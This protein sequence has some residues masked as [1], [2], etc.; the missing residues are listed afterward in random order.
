MF[1]NHSGEFAALLTAVFWTITAMAF[2]VATKRVG[3]Y[4]VNI[5][6]LFFAII[7][8]A[9]LTFFRRGMVLPMDASVHAWV[10]LSI[11]GLVGFI[12]GDLFLFASY[13]IITSR[14]SM[15][16]MTLAPPLAA[17]IGWL[18]LGETMTLISL[19]GMALVVVGIG[20][21]IWSRPDGEKKL[22]LNF[23]IKGLVFALL[24]AVGQAVGLVLSKY[25]MRDY[26]PFAATQ[27][28]I[29]AGLIGFGLI[30]SILKRWKN[31]FRVF[32]DKKS[33]SRIGLG[34]FFGPFLGVSFS[35]IAIQHTS[36]GIA[37][38]LMAIVPVL[39]I[40]PSVI[41]FKQKVTVREVVGAIISVAGVALFFV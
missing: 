34:S 30:I 23:P 40:V 16:I 38:T 39:I 33:I 12:L 26:D 17:L 20:L 24:G 35:L 32:T 37:A 21:T 18:V 14:V 9:L 25:G 1:A 15:L 4:S 29:I 3:A 7:L 36:A 27:I 5:I 41:I 19:L 22:S 31:V 2:E 13:P 11:S 10:W 28:R 8:L 6:R